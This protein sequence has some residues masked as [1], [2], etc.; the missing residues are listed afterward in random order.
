M[1]ELVELF[2]IHLEWSR[3]MALWELRTCTAEPGRQLNRIITATTPPVIS[4][5]SWAF[6]DTPPV[7]RPKRGGRR[8]SQ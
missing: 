3:Q 1:R 7:V 5:E 6:D 2:I 4:N 8:P